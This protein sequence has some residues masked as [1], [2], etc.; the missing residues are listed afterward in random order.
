MQKKCAF[1]SIDIDYSIIF[2]KIYYLY[3]TIF[4]AGKIFYTALFYT[5]NIYRIYFL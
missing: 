4:R 2:R 3:K 5:S 1:F